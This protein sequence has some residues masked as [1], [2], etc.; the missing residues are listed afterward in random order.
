MNPELRARLDDIVKRLDA[1][2]AV[3]NISFIK[4]ISRRAGSGIKAGT[5]TVATT[6]T[7]SVR[8]A[9][10]S[11]AV[12]VAKVFDNKRQII[13]ADGSIEYIGTYNS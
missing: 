3:E 13:L 10:D 12:D 5:E 7:Q 11:G 8:N 4:N 1:I 9:T 2:E 6:I